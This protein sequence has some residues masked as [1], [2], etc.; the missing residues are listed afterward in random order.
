MDAGERVDL[1]AS[2]GYLPET[3]YS[4]AGDAA[5]R[6]FK[7]HVCPPV[8]RGDILIPSPI[9]ELSAPIG[10]RYDMGLN[11]DKINDALMENMPTF[12]GIN[13]FRE[14]CVNNGYV[15]LGVNDIFM[16]KLAENIH[17]WL[18]EFTI[19][20]TIMAPNSVEYLCVRLQNYSK[21]VGEYVP[22]AAKRRA[23]WLC[24]GLLQER[25]QVKQER[26][27]RAAVRAVR[28]ALTGDDGKFGGRTAA[29]MAALLDHGNR[30]EI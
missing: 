2:M 15:C 6:F 21:A 19:P 16:V 17:D 20:R 12:D 11:G 26:A 1:E 4:I 18:T 13:V 14:T 5:Y 3:P 7:E 22:S 8:K 30:I 9:L 10:V 23:L 28:D 25:T 29:V 24:L 27:Y